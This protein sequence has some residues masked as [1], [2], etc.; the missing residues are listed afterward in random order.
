M[1][2]AKHIPSGHFVRVQSSEGSY[3]LVIE[4]EGSDCPPLQ[5]PSEKQLNIILFGVYGDRY[6]SLERPNN[7]VTIVYAPAQFQIIKVS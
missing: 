2:Q 5:A 4:D 6:Q 7:K 3:S 1:Y